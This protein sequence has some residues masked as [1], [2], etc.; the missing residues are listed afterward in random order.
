MKRNLFLIAVIM[1]LSTVVMAQQPRRGMMFQPEELK[2]ELKLNDEQV[3]KFK[4]LSTNLMTE[5]QKM[6]DSGSFDR[7]KM[8]ELRDK[9]NSDLK[10][11]FSEE[12]FKKY[13]E[14]VEKARAARQR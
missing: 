5:M 9:M 1:F 3:E 13:E 6:R 14:M 10:K 8:T 12:Q 2:Q 11:V 7:E 4:T